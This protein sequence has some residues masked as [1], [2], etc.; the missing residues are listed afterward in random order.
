MP[1]RTSSRIAMG[2]TIRNSHRRRLEISTAGLSATSFFSFPE[3]V[4]FE[5]CFFGF[6]QAYSD[7]KTEAHAGII[8]GTAAKC[9][10]SAPTLRRRRPRCSRDSALLN[11]QLVESSRCCQRVCHS[12][13]CAVAGNSGGKG[14]PRSADDSVI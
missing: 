2:A 13:D 7:S 11:L 4:F 14:L 1:P 12:F 8:N 10:R 5:E 6:K 9:K 3:R